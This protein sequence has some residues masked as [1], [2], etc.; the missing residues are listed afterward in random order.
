MSCRQTL[1]TA[2]TRSTFHFAGGVGERGGVGILEGKGEGL[3]GGTAM[4]YAG[5]IYLFIDSVE[6]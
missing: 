5:D 1:L 6:L 4:V 3:G 2:I